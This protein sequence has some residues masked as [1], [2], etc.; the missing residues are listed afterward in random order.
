[1]MIR[2]IVLLLMTTMINA[3]ENTVEKDRELFNQLRE[4]HAGLVAAK[5]F[6]AEMDKKS[7]AY[8]LKGKIKGVYVVQVDYDTTKGIDL[9]VRDTEDFYENVLYS[10]VTY[11]NTMLL[12]LLSHSGY[13]RLQK[14]FI[15]KQ[16][17]PKTFQVLF[18]K[19]DIPIKYIFTEGE[20]GLIDKIQYFEQEKKIFTLSIKWEKT[21]EYY[22]PILMKGVSYE[23]TRQA[24][25]FGIKNIQLK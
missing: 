10:Y 18:D 13:T 14:R 16:I 15:I 19:G 11:I 22:V 24:L 7:A 23:K 2:W 12:P 6:T 21:Q 9:I 4:R 1:M 25:S 17:E 5:A 8:L 3:S 20:L